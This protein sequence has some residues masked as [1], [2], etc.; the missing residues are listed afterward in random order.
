[1]TRK[2]LPG[3]GGQMPPSR[4]VIELHPDMP[5]EAGQVSRAVS[6]II[7]RNVLKYTKRTARELKTTGVSVVFMTIQHFLKELIEL[8]PEAAADYFRALGDLADEGAP[9]EAK[10]NAER[11]R[12]DARAA[13]LASLDA[14]MQENP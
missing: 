5:G 14:E 6:N 12:K 10:L 1:M 8:N 2:P 13:L 9:H 11:R 7:S 4:P 3:L